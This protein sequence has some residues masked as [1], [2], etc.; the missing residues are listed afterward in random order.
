[1]L[2]AQGSPMA[3]P[4]AAAPGGPGIQQTGGLSEFDKQELLRELDDL[5]NEGYNVSR[6]EKII[7][8]NPGNAWKAFSEFLDDIEKLNQ[9]RS[10]LENLDISGLPDLAAKKN[11]IL[12]KIND[13]DQ[14]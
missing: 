14:K 7:E 4:T 6:L 1:M 12:S 13:P 11:E 10:R 2:P 5:R 9:H 3:A 8:E